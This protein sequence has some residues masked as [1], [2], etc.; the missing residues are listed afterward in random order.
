MKF[1]LDKPVHNDSIL[2]YFIRQ[3]NKN[4]NNDK[5]SYWKSFNFGKRR[6][7]VSFQYDIYEVTDEVVIRDEKLREI[8]QFM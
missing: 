8:S 5:I 4:D 2:G 3:V 6:Y 7:V 1:N